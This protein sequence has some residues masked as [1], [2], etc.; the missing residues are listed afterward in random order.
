MEHTIAEPKDL[1]Y[2][3]GHTCHR[4]VDK[5][6]IAH[7]IPAVGYFGCV[8]NWKNKSGVDVKF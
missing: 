8:L 4:V 7:C 3:R 1:Y 2:E 6:G 5:S